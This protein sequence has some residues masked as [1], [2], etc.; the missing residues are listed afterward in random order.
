MSHQCTQ[1]WYV[2]RPTDSYET[3]RESFAWELPPDYH[4][5]TDFLE[6]HDADTTALHQAYPDGRREMF[7]FDDINARASQLAHGLA[8]LGIEP[9]D[10]VGVVLPQKPET[11]I[12]HLACWKLAAVS[13]PMTVLFGDQ[14]LRYRLRDSGAR[15]V[16]YDATIQDTIAQVQ[17]DCPA[18]EHII[19]VDATPPDEH[20]FESVTHDQPTSFAPRRTGPD[21]PAVIM[22]TSG[23]TGPPKGVFHSYAVWLGR[24]AA[25][26]VYFEHGLFETESAVTWTPSDWA[27][28]AALGGVVF[29]SWHHGVPVVGSPT[30]KF[31]PEQA[32]GLLEEFGVTDTFIPPTAL[33]MLQDVEE[34]ASRYDLS[35]R[36]IAA[37]GE[38]LT[39]EI[40]DWINSAF[41]DVTINEFYGQTELNLIVA[42]NTTWFETRPGSMGKP[43]PGYDI[44]I[45]DPDTHESLPPGEVGEITVSPHDPAVFFT[46]YWNAPEQTRA[47]RHGDWYRTGDL[48]AMDENGYLWFKA[49]A[50]DIIITSGYRVGPRE[51]ETVLLEHDAVEQVGV[52]GVPD[53]TRGEIIKAYVQPLDHAT[54]TS[55]LTR[56]LQQLVRDQLAEYEYPREIE[57]V[58]TLPQ[59]TTGKIKRD[60]LKH[61][62]KHELAEPGDPRA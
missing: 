59:T 4:P 45:R 27:W 37:V 30:G 7:T 31:R 56:E 12:T 50:D 33:R 42:N 18:L 5:A 61:Q 13:V 34:P 48:A 51:I 44:T 2:T 49:R 54:P 24:A 17:G 15:A 20:S 43:L 21:T 58:D 62:H 39:P 60:Q 9:G 55:D 22:Y 6:K 53:S 46:E 26:A 16:V 47:K 57:F 11:P 1:P 3:A 28:G 32:F 29:A 14:A 36:T 25:A 10:R 23:S 19:A 38:P 35:L 41:D 40:L 8:S 52:V